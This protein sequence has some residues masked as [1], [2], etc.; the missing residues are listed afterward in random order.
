MQGGGWVGGCK[1]G[2]RG[3]RRVREKGRMGKREEGD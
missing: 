3:N 2:E 1:K